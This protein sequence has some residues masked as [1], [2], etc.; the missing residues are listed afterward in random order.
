M[1]CCIVAD[2]SKIMR[3]LLSKIMENFGYDVIEAEDGEDLM[4]LCIKNIPDLIICDWHLPLIDGVDILLK[5]RADR[6]IKQPV[7]IF[8]S[9]VKDVDVISQ[10]LKSG[11]DDF[12]MRPFD[13]DIIASKLKI[14]KVLRRAENA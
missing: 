12:I 9:Y 13:E 8:C 7:F 3:M 11:A 4:S 5:I 1:A 14:I 2:D 10:A 6:K